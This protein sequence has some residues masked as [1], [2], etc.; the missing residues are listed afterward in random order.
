MSSANGRSFRASLFRSYC[1]ELRRIG[2][3]DQVK[4]GASAGLK[5]LLDDP[6][7]AP[8][9]MGPEP[10]DELAVAIEALRGREAMRELGYRVMKTG[11][12]AVLEPIIHLALSIAGSPASLFSRANLM[13]AV[14]SRGVEM[15]WKP[16][17]K[18]A[19]T[20]SVRCDDPIPA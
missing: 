15:T 9:W 14:V 7:Q 1:D 3:F 20:M 12:T 4:A 6:R 13:L 2:I 8:S 5:L 18:T 11:F 17:G 19:G 16:A 10:F